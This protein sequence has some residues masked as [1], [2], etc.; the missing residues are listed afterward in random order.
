MTR[1]SD[2]PAQPGQ[3]AAGGQQGGRGRH[4]PLLIRPAAPVDFASILTLNAA[5]VH[6]LSPLDHERLVLLHEQASL[7]LVG[8]VDGEVAA[9]LLA[10]REGSDYDSVNYRWFAERY[11]HF[12][13][14][15]R[16]VIDAGFRGRGAG[17]A[18]YRKVFEFARQTG[19]SLVTC[20]IDRD[21]PNLVSEQFHLR[22][23]FAEVGRQR[24]PYA[25]KMVSMQLARVSE[26]PGPELSRR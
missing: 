13:Y 21:P 18:L 6:F 7:H 3:R 2:R 9:F 15:D 22:F 26:V 4:A 10:F 24:V 20:E 25:P 5:S 19:V 1:P 16:I 14:I 8:E 17:L 23:G 11:Q 12:L